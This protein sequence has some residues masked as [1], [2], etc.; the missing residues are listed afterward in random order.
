MITD[1][2]ANSPQVIALTGTGTVVQLTP[3][4]V[5]FGE[6]RVGTVSHPQSVTLTNTGS[7]PLSIRGIGIVGRNFSDFIET[8]TCGSSVPANSSCEIDVRF[9][10]SDAGTRTAS[11]KVQHDGGGEQPVKLRGT[12][13]SN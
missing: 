4:S 7:T 9:A 13:V 1:T 2:A 3:T 10:P 12:G 6:Q 11:M 5:N 8:T